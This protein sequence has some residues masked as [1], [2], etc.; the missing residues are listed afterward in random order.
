MGPGNKLL[1]SGISNFASCA[2]RGTPNLLGRFLPFPI[3]RRHSYFT[4]KVPAK[5]LTLENS[6]HH[7]GESS[8]IGREDPAQVGWVSTLLLA[9]LTK[10]LL[11]EQAD[12]L[13]LT[14]YQLGPI[15]R[16]NT[17]IT[18]YYAKGNHNHT[19]TLYTVTQKSE[20]LDVW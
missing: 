10:D 1:R 3:Q 20:P 9:Q 13:I 6:Q 7:I 11:G 15:Y 19:Y 14:Q 2:A 8:E 17:T 12:H 5:N 4:A 16:N 18:V